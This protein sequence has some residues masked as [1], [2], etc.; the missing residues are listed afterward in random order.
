MFLARILAASVFLA[1]A[2]ALAAP[3]PPVASQALL[4]QSFAGWTQTAPPTSVSN[5][6]DAAALH[7]YGLSQSAAA[8]YASGEQHLTVRAFRF[9]DATG[10]Y[11]AFTFFRQ[12][13]MRV[14]SIGHD[15]ASS[16]DHFLFWTGNSVVDATFSQPSPDEK[17]ALTALAAQC[18]Q[19]G[20][21]AGI[22]PTL[23]RYLPTAQLNAST[24][25]YVIGPAAYARIGGKLPASA[26]DFS[27]D[28]EVVTAQ[29]GPPGAQGTLTILSYPT[30]QI[31]GAH[32]KALDALA[33][34]SSF[35]TKRSGPLVAIVTGSSSQQNTQRLLSAVHFEDYVTINHPEGYVPETV[36]LYR[37]LVGITMFVV[38]LVSAAVLLG[39][40]LGGGRALFRFLRGKPVSSVS[41]E[42]FIS[43]HLS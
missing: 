22:P 8:I 38:V 33:K 9:A 16:G 28:T 15:A 19:I 7:E 40:F 3:K 43:L 5:A 25:K 29:Y 31:A 11:G 26:I 4:P 12:P 6:A 32:L 18:P 30:P 10:A 20:G 39:L 24:V 27:Q 41:E 34:S 17:S 14:E 37:L 21:A 23:P 42:E 36:K 2:L 35:S 13:G 1:S